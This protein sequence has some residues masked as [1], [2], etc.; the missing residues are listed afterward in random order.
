MKKIRAVV[1]DDEFYNRG[2][3]SKLVIK[4]HSGFEIVGTAED[5]ED[6]YELINSLQ[7]DLIFLDIKMPGGSG[8][9]LL[10]KFENPSFEVVFVT[11][12]DE[13]ARQAF[14]FNALDYILKP[15][16]SVKLK[17]TLDKVYHRIFNQ[18][19][20]TDNLKEITKLYHINSAELSKIPIHVKD[21]V[22]LLAINDIISI[23]SED[24]Y[25]VFTDIYFN[26]YISA[27]SLCDFEFI[28]DAIPHFV[29]LHKSIYVNSNYVKHYTKGQICI[30]TMAD[31]STFEVSRRKK[32]E[33]L[34]FLDKKMV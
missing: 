10:R 20:T 12:F 8:F 25:T 21:K 26:K 2:L 28:F 5:I 16:D 19:S 23:Q 24:G 1:I 9:D 30:I 3:I 29:R 17:K 13:Y 33:I 15:I 7:P 34:A 22:V 4:S 18:L 6:G 27:K 31:N 11:G 14:E 32:A